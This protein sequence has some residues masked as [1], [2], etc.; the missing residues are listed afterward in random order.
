MTEEQEAVEVEPVARII[1]TLNRRV[2]TSDTKVDTEIESY[3]EDDSYPTLTQVLQMI[4]EASGALIS[5]YHNE[6]NEQ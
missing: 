1:I 5:L 3:E 4:G 6:A 2:E